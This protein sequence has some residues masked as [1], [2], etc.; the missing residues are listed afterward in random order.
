M[1][2]LK[3]LL[4]KTGRVRVFA[5]QEEANL[6]SVWDCALDVMELLIARGVRVSLARRVLRVVAELLDNVSHYQPC[7]RTRGCERYGIE[8]WQTD[9]GAVDV[10]ISNFVLERDVA[11]LS[12]HLERVKGYTIVEAKRM[13]QRALR[14]GINT[15]VSGAGIGLL[16]VRQRVKR[17]DWRFEP[18]EGGCA[19]FVIGLRVL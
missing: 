17:L 1:F 18:E 19:R 6:A 9:R 11:E 5:R 16:T 10:E 4:E 14:V 15:S 2:M 12:K 7:V 8:V 13:M 3:P